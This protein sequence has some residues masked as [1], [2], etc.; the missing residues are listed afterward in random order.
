MAVLAI[1]FALWAYFNVRGT[2]DGPLYSG[3]A[4]VV[5]AVLVWDA[6]TWKKDWPVSVYLVFILLWRLGILAVQLYHGQALKTLDYGTPLP[7]TYLIATGVID[8]RRKRS[9][10]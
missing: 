5:A 4:L 6:R 7:L 1:V 3:L 8:H 9:A 2:P 10:P